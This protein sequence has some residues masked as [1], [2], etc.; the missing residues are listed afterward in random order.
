MEQF[1]D[2]AHLLLLHRHKTVKDAKRALADLNAF[3][4]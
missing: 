4:F 2:Q 1:V 3:I